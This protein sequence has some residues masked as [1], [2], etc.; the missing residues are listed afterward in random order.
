M[1]RL[2]KDLVVDCLRRYVQARL[3]G[4]YIEPGA[5]ARQPRAGAIAFASGDTFARVSAVGTLGLGVDAAVKKPRTR[6]RF[7]KS[8]GSAQQALCDASRA[9][10]RAVP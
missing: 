8:V 1:E 5:S 3:C 6:P 7:A 2:G 10:I 9:D 4:G